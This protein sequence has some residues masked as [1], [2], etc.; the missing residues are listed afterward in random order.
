MNLQADQLLTIMPKLGPSRAARYVEPLRKAMRES[1]I[2]TPQRVA[3]FLAQVAHE[4]GELRWWTELWGPTAQQRR[5]DPP[6]PLAARLGN[7]ER[8]DGFRYR[9]RGPPQ[10]TG[11][12][13]YR[14]AG[15]ALGLDLVEEPDLAAEPEHGFRVAGWFWTEIGGNMY[16]DRGEF[17]QITRAWNGGQN[18]ADSRRAYHRVALDT[19]SDVLDR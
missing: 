10:L 6:D 1:G 8:G 17:D 19:L 11:K 12:A 9:G 5:Y 18:G 15:N 13:N 4:S 2:T 3:A 14:R 7:T 16:A